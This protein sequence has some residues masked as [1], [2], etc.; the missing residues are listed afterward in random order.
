MPTH[1]WKQL[2]VVVGLTPQQSKPFAFSGVQH[3]SIMIWLIWLTLQ[4][5]TRPQ[6]SATQC[7]HTVTFAFTH[8]SLTIIIQLTGNTAGWNMITIETCGSTALRG[9]ERRWSYVCVSMD[10]K[11]YKSCSWVLL[12]PSQHPNKPRASPPWCN[13]LSN[14]LPLLLHPRRR[15]GARSVSV[16]KVLVFQR[17]RER[18]RNTL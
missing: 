7:T 4:A 1:R 12:L 5:T 13:R 8:L 16:S 10:C 14:F 3:Q 15:G 2:I 18:E 11:L 6:N 17:E 9:S